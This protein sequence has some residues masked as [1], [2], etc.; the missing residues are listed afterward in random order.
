[1]FIDFVGLN[2]FVNSEINGNTLE[3]KNVQNF[4]D[5]DDARHITASTASE[6]NGELGSGRSATTTAIYFWVYYKTSTTNDDNFVFNFE[7]EITEAELDHQVNLELILI[8]TLQMAV[9]Q[10]TN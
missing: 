2:T 7:T 6:L 9:F 5:L 4:Y 8:L 1:M 10:A 3:F